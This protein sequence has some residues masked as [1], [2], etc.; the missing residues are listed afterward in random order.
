MKWI[1][2]MPGGERMTESFSPSI[3]RIEARAN[4]MPR[5][6]E[7]SLG[8]EW[9]F[10]YYPKLD[11]LPEEMDLTALESWDRIDV[12]GCWQLKGYGS[13]KY[14]NTRYEFEPDALKLTPPHVPSERTAV[15]VYA[16]KFAYA[17]D[18]SRRILLALDGFGSCAQVYLNGKFVG[19]AANGRSVAEFDVSSAVCAGENTLVIAVY[20][21]GAGSF[22]ECQDMWRLSGLFRDVRI[23][24]VARVALHDVYLWY[25]VERDLSRACVHAEVKIHNSSAELAPPVQVECE[26]IGPD[27]RTV[28]RAEG[29]TGNL[30]ARFEEFVFTKDPLPVQAG[31]TRTAY[32][33]ID[34]DAPR[35]WSADDPQLYTLVVRAA[36]QECSLRCGIRDVRIE[37]GVFYVNYA[38][39]KLK[40]VNR[41]EF[42]PDNG[43]V[44]TREEM[45]RDILLMKQHNVNAVRSSHYPNAPEWYALC[46]EYGLYVMDEANIESHGISYRA[47]IL[48]GNDM[49]WLPHVLDR[50]TAMVECQKNHPSVVMWSIGNELGFGETVAAAAGLIRSLDP[51]P[52]HKRQMNVIADMDS[53]TYPTVD[54]MREH[55][56]KK[57]GRA[58]VANE[59]GHAMGNAC[60]SLSDYWDAIYADPTLIGGFIWEWCDHGLRG[61]A[62]PYSYGGDFGEEFHDGNFCIDGL[63]LPDRQPT[64]KMQ[65]LK[66]VHENVSVL[67]DPDRQVMRILN[68]FPHTSL[69]KYR[70]R[71]ALLSDGAEVYCGECDLNGIAPGETA[72]RKYTLPETLPE[73]E[74]VLSASIAAAQDMPW[75][76]AGHEIAWAQVRLRAAQTQALPE[77]NAGYT[78][79][80]DNAPAAV[81]GKWN[82]GVLSAECAGTRL[83]YLPNGELRAEHDGRAWISGVELNAYRA[84]T[85]NDARAELMSKY[86]GTGLTWSGLGLDHLQREL[87]E[88]HWGMERGGL[89]VTRRLRHSGNGCA[90][91]LTQRDTLTGDGRVFVDCDVQIEGAPLL[92][93]LGLMLRA[94]ASLRG[95]RWYGAGPEETYPDRQSGGRLG[96]FETDVC[97][98]KGYIK[99]QEYGSHMRTRYLNLRGEGMELTLTGAI[100]CAMSALAHSP[101]MLAAAGH[102]DELPASDATYVFVDY[103]Q[104]GL[105]NRSCGPDA[106]PQYRL[107]AAEARFGVLIS[108]RGYEGC[109]L[110]EELRDVY[111]AYVGGTERAQA[112]YRD[113]SD[114]DQQRAV[115]MDV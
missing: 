80:L 82:G 102:E 21:F 86:M 90:L 35:L 76:E 79:L 48:P 57:P 104:D 30:S 51:R 36:G 3:N 112:E 44:V 92:P 59:Y 95:M 29:Y 109:A 9:A 40:G 18:L 63:V 12:P 6:D 56:K 71:Y 64:A 23:Y 60:G 31:V 89:T 62:H 13:P 7:Q 55:S 28:A 11:E 65:E 67:F 58:F 75:C 69:D 108:P 26:L 10:R 2:Q 38:P 54:F 43:Y 53:E 88:M 77:S 87:L 72:E 17:G 14:I 84:P 61:G 74:L 94:D 27:G 68:R 73:G 24:S 115:G 93:R 34:V 107:T 15:G 25:D 78:V 106:L 98:Q 22:L 1:M 20:Q 105:G 100:P 42:S 96:V 47:N 111:R 39:V 50:V 103:A 81:E 52:I 99:P 45:V 91:L 37:Q 19:Y 97:A 110:P 113:P 83:T 70:L 101:Q 41:H 85:D 49:R 66:K 32:V 33:N 4:F 5:E 46:D 16:R 8:G 114:P